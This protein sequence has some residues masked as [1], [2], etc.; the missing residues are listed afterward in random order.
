MMY[1]VFLHFKMSV[2]EQHA[3]S[4]THKNNNHTNKINAIYFQE[5]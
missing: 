5:K 4:V 2:L 3:F 1:S